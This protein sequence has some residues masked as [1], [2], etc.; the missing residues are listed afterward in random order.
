MGGCSYYGVGHYK[1][2]RQIWITK[3]YMNKVEVN[4]ISCSCSNQDKLFIVTMLTNLSSSR[5]LY[6]FTIKEN[7]NSPK[8]PSNQTKSNYPVGNQSL[9]LD[10]QNSYQHQ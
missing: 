7:F 4:A 9:L 3:V 6:L 2:E 8:S 10:T 5:C 1:K